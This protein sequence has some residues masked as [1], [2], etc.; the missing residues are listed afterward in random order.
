M[1]GTEKMTLGVKEFQGDSQF[2]KM[3]VIDFQQLVTKPE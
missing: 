3:K 1:G 2:Y